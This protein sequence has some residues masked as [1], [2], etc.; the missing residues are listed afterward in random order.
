[1]A[2]PQQSN[3]MAVCR[4]RT[5][6]EPP[7]RCP[8]WL[9][10]ACLLNLPRMHLR[11]MAGRLPDGVH[12]ADMAASQ[13]FTK[14]A[15]EPFLPIGDNEHRTLFLG[16]STITVILSQ[17]LPPGCPHLLLP[18]YSAK[19]LSRLRDPHLVISICNWIT[20]SVGNNEN[21]H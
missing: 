9:V 2:R 5:L 10:H 1:M 15:E 13:S 8:R 4:A 12:V 17:Q 11:P 7:S 19:Q 6:P 20:C 18:V 14:S 16:S 21:Q 3:L